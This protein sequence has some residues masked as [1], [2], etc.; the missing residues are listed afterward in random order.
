MKRQILLLIVMSIMSLSSSAQIQNIKL[1]N[2]QLYFERVYEV[3][4]LSSQ[5]MEQFLTYNI[6]KINN[7][8]DFSINNYVITAKLRGVV[9]NYRKYG[10]KWGSTPSY[11]NHPFSCDI[12]IIWKEKKYRVSATNMS[13]YLPG[14]NYTLLYNLVAKKDVSELRESQLAALSY[15]EQ[16]LS[17]LFTIKIT[18]NEEW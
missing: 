3:D 13:F 15:I 10:A 2:G 11:M 16:F 1:E 12:K 9:I 17:D 8:N 4:S 5:N 6:S 18:T 7:I 14:N